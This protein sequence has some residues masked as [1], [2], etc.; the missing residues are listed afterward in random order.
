MNGE[1]E[2]TMEKLTFEQLPEAVTELLATV[3]RIEAL[4]TKKGVTVEESDILTV[5]Q[6]CQYLN[7]SKSCMY[8]KTSLGDIPFIKY[9]KYLRFEKKA[10]KDVLLQYRVKSNVEIEQEAVNYIAQHTL[11]GKK[12]KAARY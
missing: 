9:G 10:L 3:K 5:A 4:L 2:Q 6:A 12:R 1:P 8:K 7:I 11:G